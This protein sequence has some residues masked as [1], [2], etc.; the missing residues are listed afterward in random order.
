MGSASRALH[1]RHEVASSGIGSPKIGAGFGF[2]VDF[3]V[4]CIW[5]FSFAIANIC[6][7]SLLKSTEG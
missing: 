1:L 5:S 2:G 6:E 7:P 4:G 3:W